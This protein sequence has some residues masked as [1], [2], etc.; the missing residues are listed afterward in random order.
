MVGKILVR[1]ISTVQNPE[2][3]QEMEF[4]SG[5][6]MQAN[7]VHPISTVRQPYPSR[8]SEISP[9]LHRRFLRYLSGLALKI[10][11]KSLQQPRITS[12]EKT[13]ENRDLAG[14]AADQ[15]KY[16]AVRDPTP[17]AA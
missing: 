9:R 7:G 6:R 12:R 1:P 13:P 16:S 15:S 4:H 5:N 10:E 2:I 14:L 11:E 3:P 8:V 17:G